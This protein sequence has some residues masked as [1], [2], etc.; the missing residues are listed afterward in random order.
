MNTIGTQSI[1]SHDKVVT[2]SMAQG[3]SDKNAVAG[4]EKVNTR[5][6]LGV[7][8]ERTHAGLV[9]RT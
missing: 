4:S 5:F 9:D 6:R 1:T 2:D 3:G 7:K 8:I